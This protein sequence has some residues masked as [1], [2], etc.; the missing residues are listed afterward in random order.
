MIDA[1]HGGVD[2]GAR[3][4]NGVNEKD[5]S[6]ALARGIRAELTRR[7]FRVVMTRDADTDPAFDDRAA[8]ANQFADAI[9]IS[10]HVAS[11]GTAGT[12]RAYFY[13]IAT[14]FAT[15]VPAAGVET[16][17][18]PTTPTPSPP[19]GLVP[20]REA[21]AAFD[22]GSHRF[23]DA[24]Q[25]G[26]AQKFSGSPATGTSAAVRDLRSVAAPAISIELSSVAS[27]NASSLEAMGPS[28]A[29]AIAQGIL[30]FHP[31]GMPGGSAATS[32]SVPGILVPS[33]AGPAGGG[34]H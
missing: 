20:W 5:V 29:S 3:G 12:V 26:L 21:Q 2:N 24:V 4:P 33:P 14:P 8:T 22:D 19:G 16:N 1:A 25:A 17:S 6:L 32:P 27:L 15:I 13:R 9:Y 11:T 30:E 31:F 10:L 7:G 34:T 28:V 18:Q 23:A